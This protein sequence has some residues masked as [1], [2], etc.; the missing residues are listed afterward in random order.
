MPITATH[1]AYYHVCHR[2]VWLFHHGIQMEHTSELVAE[3]KLID[4]HSYPQRAAKWQQL[5][6]PGIKIDYF[7]PK[8]FKLREVKKSNK[9]EAAH[10]AQV[11][12]YMYILRQHDIPVKKTILEYPKLRITEEVAWE[13]VD[14]ES[15]ET[16]IN[17]VHEIIEDLQCPPRINKPICKKCAYYEFCYAEEL[18]P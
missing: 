1:I 7:D 14:E 17:A 15:V 2:K 8:S 3:G 18:E 11:K 16:W 12:Y 10:L 13:D 9:K 6:L 5:E 4:E